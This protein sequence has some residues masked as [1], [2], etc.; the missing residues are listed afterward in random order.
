MGLERH[1][2]NTYYNN[3][4]LIHILLNSV[5]CQC[6]IYN[7]HL[8]FHLIF[9]YLIFVFLLLQP[10]LLGRSTQSSAP[11]QKWVDFDCLCKSIWF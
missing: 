8:W 10:H 5:S 1:D 4:I 6:N 3:I 2:Y 9:A 7:I 11:K